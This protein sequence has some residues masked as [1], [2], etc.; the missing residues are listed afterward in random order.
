MYDAS[1]HVFSSKAANLGQFS[2]DLAVKFQTVYS[3][4]Q[5]YCNIALHLC[6]YFV[7]RENQAA[8]NDCT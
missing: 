4:E 5:S 6:L 2:G 8:I 1:L 3:G 7:I